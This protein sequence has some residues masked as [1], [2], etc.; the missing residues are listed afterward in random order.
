MSDEIEI[1]ELHLDEKT[2]YSELTRRDVRSLVLHLLY[3]VSAH[4]YDISLNTVI[5]GI[6]NSFDFEIPQ[7]SEAYQI[8]KDIIDK[9]IELDT[10]LAPYLKNW[11]IDRLGMCTLLIM[12]MALWELKYT[13]TAPIIV[14]NEAI[15]LAKHFSEKDAYKF[16]NG[17]LDQIVKDVAKD[18]LVD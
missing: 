3:I 4:D 14:M 12:R 6:H 17:I 11:T 10:E 2:K 1:S 5:D 18:K 15:E 16:I 9:R 7:D 8:T 13:D